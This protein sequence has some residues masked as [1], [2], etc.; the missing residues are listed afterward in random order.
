M[1]LLLFILVPLIMFAV[2]ASQFAKAAETF[3]GIKKNQQAYKLQRE[4]YAKNPGATQKDFL[5]WYVKSRQNV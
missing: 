5:D 2:G 3:S 4:F 1:E